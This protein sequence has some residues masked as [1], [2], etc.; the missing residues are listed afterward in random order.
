MQ[1]L[2][3]EIKAR[4]YQFNPQDLDLPEEFKIDPELYYDLF[5]IAANIQLRILNM[6][7]DHVNHPA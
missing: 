7:G 4:A 5:D 6:L 2:E 3:D 1:N